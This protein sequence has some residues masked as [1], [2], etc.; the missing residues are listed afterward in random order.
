MKNRNSLFHYFCDLLFHYFCDLLYATQSLSHLSLFYSCLFCFYFIL[1]ITNQICIVIFV[2]L[3]DFAPFFFLLKRNFKIS[4][5]EVTNN[6]FTLRSSKSSKKLTYYLKDIFLWALMSQSCCF[7][8]QIIYVF[9]NN[10]FKYKERFFCF[11]SSVKI[12]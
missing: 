9:L 12:I 10:F 3:F 1:I 8:C 11:Q 7:S 2:F 4:E 6:S 5:N